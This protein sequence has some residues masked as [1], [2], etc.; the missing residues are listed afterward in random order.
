MPRAVFVASAVAEFAF[1]DR[2]AYRVTLSCGCTYWEYRPIG[3]APPEVGRGE[4]CHADAHT[5]SRSPRG[6][7]CHGDGAIRPNPRYR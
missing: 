1:N 4:L 6:G 7:S 3:E 5:S 2:I